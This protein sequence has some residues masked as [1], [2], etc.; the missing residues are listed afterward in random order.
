M[1]HAQSQAICSLSW[2]WR[3]RFLLVSSVWFHCWQPY[4]PHVWTGR[5]EEEVLGFAV[6]VPAR[7]RK[8]GGGNNTRA[9]GR[10]NHIAGTAL[11][12]DLNLWAERQATFSGSAANVCLPPLLQHNLSSH[13]S[14]RLM[15]VS[16]SQ[17]RK[18]GWY[19]GEGGS[20]VEAGSFARG[21]SQNPQGDEEGVRF[22]SEV[23][24]VC[25]IWCSY[26]LDHCSESQLYSFV[27]I[28]YTL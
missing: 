22:Y 17:H 21:A 5:A 25:E 24:L 15:A 11:I 4:Q 7:G 23:G 10:G 12:T 6:V 13:P 14:A 16:V 9:R 26:H 18:Q 20:G 28:S 2:T 19:K 3:L 27:V 1:E 8:R